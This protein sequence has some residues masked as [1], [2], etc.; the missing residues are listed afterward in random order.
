M[1][2]HSESG[3]NTANG[4]RTSNI[5]Q[6]KLDALGEFIEL[7]SKF[8]LNRH[9][10]SDLFHAVKGRS[11]FSTVLLSLH[12]QATPFLRRYA[13]Q[14]VPVLLHDEPW[15]LARK[16][17]AIQRGNHPSTRAYSNFIQEE[18]TDMRS[19][20]MI[21]ILPY[22]LVRHLRP[23]QILPLGCVPQRE[24]R[25][26]I[27]ND[28]TFSGVNPSTVKMAPPETMQWGRTLNRVLW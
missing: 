13:S 19:K 9:S 16:D 27:I 15:T 28:Y 5:A 1:V 21:I 14:G 6:R 2:H 7:D 12:H 11:N 23:L 20:G 22:Q 25:P 17:A 8:L 10:W 24:R 3:S 18:M 26:R 4:R